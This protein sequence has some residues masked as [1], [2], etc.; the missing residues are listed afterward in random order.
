MKKRSP[1]FDAILSILL[2]LGLAVLIYTVR[3]GPLPLTQQIRNMQAAEAHVPTLQPRLNADARYI[4]LKAGVW[5]GEGGCLSIHGVLSSEADF[6]DLKKLVKAS[7][8]PVGIV[9][10]LELPTGEH[11]GGW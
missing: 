5:T 2:L 6:P 4:H 7:S 10:H 3:Y 11:F 9:Y 1:R 8:P